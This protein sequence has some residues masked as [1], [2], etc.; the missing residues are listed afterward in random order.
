MPPMKRRH[1][2]NVGLVLLLLLPWTTTATAQT[3]KTSGTLEGTISDTSGARIPT[4]KVSLREVDTNQMRTVSADDRGFFRA[5]DLPVGT[6]EV[7]AEVAGFAPFLHTG[8]LLDVGTT[9]H[10]DI[11]LQPLGVTAE[12]TV[13]A[14]PSPIDPSQTSVT[15]AIDRQRIEDLPILSRNSLDFALLL[16][17]VASSSQRSGTGSHPGLAD[18]GFT[19]GGLRA[20]SNNISVDGVDNNDEF[21]GSSRTELSPEDVQEYQ[22][23]NN[24]LS[25]EYGGASGGSINVVTRTGANVTF[26]DGYIYVQNAALNAQDPL[27]TT[28]GT[29]DFRRYRGGASVGGPIVKNRTFFHAAFE[30]ESNNGQLGSDIDPSVASSLNNFLATGAF[31]RLK[32]RQIATGFS[33]IT[34]TETEASGK[35]NHQIDATNSLMLRYA[36]TDN[37]VNGNA[38]NTTS[39]QDASARG[40]SSTTD[41]DVAGSLVSIF[42]SRGVGDLRFQ[43]ATRHAV[44]HTNQ[45]AGP[46]IDIVGLI[47]FGQPSD[48]NTDRRE[49]QYE[50]SYSY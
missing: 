29:P 48:G 5:T 18:S 42:G 4:A 39:L 40:S 32:T 15:S 14:Q 8:V 30:Q 6:Y 28:P 22:V 25:A 49:H 46:G 10:L 21:T 19:F 31:P 26:G 20:R 27:Q 13:S 1:I 2:A 33:P 7:R 41:S 36:F 38:F 3:L 23:V 35:L 47:D 11:V 44:L 16:P 24:G 34:R 17:G 43:V 50:V 12:V 45:T 37:Q 9:T